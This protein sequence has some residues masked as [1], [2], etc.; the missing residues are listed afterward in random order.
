VL[1]E[2]VRNPGE[3]D[4]AAGGG[5]RRVGPSYNDAMAAQIDAARSAGAGDL[6]KLL[7]GK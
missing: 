5:G 6:A 3:G 7:S 2:C 1:W 4:V